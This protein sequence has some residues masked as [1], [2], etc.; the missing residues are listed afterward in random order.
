MPL[1]GWFFVALGTASGAWGITD[2][3]AGSPLTGMAGVVGMIVA[4]AAAMIQGD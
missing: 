4:Y 2:T 3:L 1:F